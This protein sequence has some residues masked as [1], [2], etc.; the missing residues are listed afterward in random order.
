M[1]DQAGKK[2]IKKPLSISILHLKAYIVLQIL[3]YSYIKLK[4]RIW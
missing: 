3:N 4:N 2:Q 1:L